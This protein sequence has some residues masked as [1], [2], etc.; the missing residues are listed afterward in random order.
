MENTKETGWPYKAW[1]R[2]SGFVVAFFKLMRD[3]FNRY[4]YVVLKAIVLQKMRVYLSS[5][6]TF[7]FSFSLKRISLGKY[8]LASD[9]QIR[10]FL[11]MVEKLVCDEHA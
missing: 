8:Q 7:D 5:F 1:S 6:F 4:Q 2:A 11:M 9:R 10:L 3:Q